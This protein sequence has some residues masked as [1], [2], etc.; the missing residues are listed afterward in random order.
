MS[1]LHLPPAKDYF[2]NCHIHN[3]GLYN[4]VQRLWAQQKQKAAWL[5][6]RKVSPEQASNKR[7][8]KREDKMANHYRNFTRQTAMLPESVEVRRLVVKSI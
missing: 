6:K 8:C 7:K 3:P 1:T 2:L 4:P 5:Y